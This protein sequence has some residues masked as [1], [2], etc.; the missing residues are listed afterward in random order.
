M[1]AACHAAMLLD[2]RRCCCYG[3]ATLIFAFTL[4]SLID[5]AM[6]LLRHMLLSP[7]ARYYAA[8][9]IAADA[10]AAAML[11]LPAYAIRGLIIIDYAADY[12][13]PPFVTRRHFPFAHATRH[14][15]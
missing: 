1:R 12:A 10:I 6:P 11:L 8:I 15:L 14:R 5:A 3:Y 4:L 2:A 9:D 13:L 7:F